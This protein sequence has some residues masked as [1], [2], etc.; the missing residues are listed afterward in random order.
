MD[1]MRSG[2][3]SCVQVPYN[4]RERVVEERLLPLAVS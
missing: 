2:R 4:V 1:I 3:V